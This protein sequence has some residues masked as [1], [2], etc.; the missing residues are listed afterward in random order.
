MQAVTQQHIDAKLSELGLSSV[1]GPL[2]QD[3]DIHEQVGSGS[4]GLVCR[5]TCRYSNRSVAIKLIK[6]FSKYEYDCVKVSREIEIMKGV[7]STARNGTCCFIPE[8][9]DA[10]LPK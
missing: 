10:I 9:L 4:F 1:W 7:Q 5:A 6:E 2:I 8:L 3:Y